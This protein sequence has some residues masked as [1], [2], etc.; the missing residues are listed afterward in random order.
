MV[1]K[2]SLENGVFHKMTENEKELILHFNNTKT[3]YPKNK[4]LHELFEEQAMKTPDHTALVF[5]A[6]RMTYRELN[7]KANQTARLLR[8]KGIGRGSIAAIIADR[9]FEMIIGIIGILKAGGAYLPIDP[10]TPKDR[11]AFMLSDTKAAVL[12][13]QG[14]AADGIDC[15]ADIVQLDREASDGFS[16]E[17]L[18]SVNDSGDTAYIIYTSGSTGTPKG[19]VTPHYSVIRVVQNTNYID[20]TEDDVIL[21]LSNY[22]F[23]GSVFDIFGALLNGASLVMIEK[24]AL[25]NINRLG[26]AINEGKVSV[27]FITT[28]LFNMIADIHVDCLSNLRKILFG[29]ERASIPHVRKVLNHVGRDK[30]IHVY[31]PTESTVY[32][33][34]YFINEIDDEA[35]TIPIGSPL[36]N[37]SVLIMDEA[38]KLLP[39][40]VPGELCIAGDGLSK[41]YLNREELTAEKFIPHPFIPGE[42]L[43]KTG[44]LAKWLPDGNIEFIGRID[45]QVKIRGF[46]IE[47][48]EI[49][50]RLEMHE[51]INETIVT[52]REDEESRPYICAYITANRE[53]SLDELKGFLGEKLPEY[54]IPAYF[55]N[56]DKLP[57]TK[58]GKVD[59]KALPEP[60]RS[61]GT[62]AEYE[63]PRNYVEQ[64]IISI[65]EDVLGTERMGISCHFFDKGGNSL[66]AMQAVH[67][68]NKTF[69]INMRI[70][71]FFKHPTAKSLARFILTAEAESAVSEEYAEEEV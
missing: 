38:G 46:R 4:T 67:S 10:E 68:I 9:S 14:K 47:L 41:G 39:I 15:E 27:M 35:E 17:P 18:S 55:V 26:S 51:D 21:Q 50:S 24:E 32:A 44:D 40:G 48:G 28:A 70:S 45:H 29:G 65:L 54:M 12:L 23:D 6:Q 13:T 25:L 69:G 58:N 19:V 52:V 34:Y 56:M 61:A 63:A 2:H 71:T 30:L 64:R 3:D 8:E 16:K 5:G 49:E 31:G 42:R 59:R 66:K 37:T 43:Y 22:S 1:A 60:D 57:L 36:A 20:I 62:E 11:I 33:T 53:I 7:E